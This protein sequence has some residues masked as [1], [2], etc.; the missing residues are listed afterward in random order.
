[1]PNPKSRSLH[2]A[3]T[4]VLKAISASIRI[5]ILNLMLERGPLSYTEIM[6][7]L[8]LDATRDAGRFAYHLKSLLRADLIEPDVDSKK[9][10]L[11]DLGRRIIEITDEIEDRTF[12]RR[13]M[14]V[15]T[16]RLTIEEFDRNKITQSLITEAN[17]P[18]D[19]AQKIARETEKRLQQFKTKYLTAPLIREIVNTILLEKH[20]ENYR[21]KLTRLG[22]P[23]HEVTRLINAPR[24]N[25]EAVHKAAGNAVMEEYTLLN[26]L[27]RTISDAHLSGSIHLHNLGTWI[28]KINEVTQSLPYFFKMYEPKTLSA[29]LDITTN[30]IRNTLTETTGYQ[31]LADFNIYLARFAKNVNPDEIQKLFH[32]FFTNL[33]QTTSTPVT[34]SLELSST[35]SGEY[36]EESNQLARMLLETL[37]AENDK[38]PL[39]NPK[40]IIK[41]RQ[42]TLNSEEESLF[43][44]AHKLASTSIL[45]YFA[46][47]CPENQKNASYTASGLRLADEWHQDW[48]LDTRRTGNLDRISINLP[49]LSF[50]AK[51]DEAKFLELLD[52]QLKIS[53]QALGIKYE[54]IR[55]RT[56]QRL[57][58]YLMRSTNGDRYFRLENTTRTIALVGIYEAAEKILDKKITED[59]GKAYVL[60][61][62]ILKH[63]NNYTKKHTKK[64]NTRLITAAI[65]NKQVSRRLARLDVEKYGW[66]IV[67]TQGTKER[68]YYVGANKIYPKTKDQINLEELMHQLTP[69]GHFALI[70]PEAQQLSADQ[71]LAT[72]KQLMSTDI[73][74]FAYNIA[75]TNCNHCRKTSN[76]SFLKCP[77]CGATSIKTLSYFQ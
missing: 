66:S 28:L 18:T 55:K 4:L 71:L 40:I 17:V 68:P 69:G 26:I 3:G 57:L 11:T 6:N 30:V 59:I 35:K 52:E 16:S 12:K 65:P 34:L 73:G 67:R 49:R 61:E 48:E 58:P 24:Q 39:R 13:K 37:T 43:Y 10:H 56:E 45:T 47:L 63:I 44:E 60:I 53:N 77:I 22:L 33:N 27:P 31:N 38:K 70:S 50:E 15:R 76:G 32:L 2:K 5:Q 29:A 62:R 54:M 51:A 8:K 75:L 14:L 9:Y 36:F 25:V 72:T 74:F 42:E 7:F 19:L 41:A 20:H 23:V 21:H 64:P 46:N 1:M